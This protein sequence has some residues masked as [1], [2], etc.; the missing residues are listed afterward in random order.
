MADTLEELAEQMGVPA[1]VFVA[2]MNKYN[3]YV[4]NQL[5]PEFGKKNLAPTRNTSFLCYAKNPIRASY[6]GRP[7][8]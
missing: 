4:E 7:G 5:D 2:E 1:D 6:D 8:N 3:T